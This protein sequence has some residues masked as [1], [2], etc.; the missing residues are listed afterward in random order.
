MEN[1]KLKIAMLF[2]ADDS[3]HFLEAFF[4]K[5]PDLSCT[6]ERCPLDISPEQI[7]LRHAPQMVVA[8]LV[9]LSDEEQFQLKD[10][11]KKISEVVPLVG[12]MDEKLKSRALEYVKI[13]MRDFIQVPFDEDDL[14]QVIARFRQGALPSALRKTGKA[15][16]FL[17]FK[18][19]VGNTF[20]AVNTAVTL[21]RMSQ[22]K[23]L[24]W[25]MALQS[26]D[27][28]F[29]LNCN[30]K[31][32]L[33]EIIQNLDQVDESYLKGVLP[34]TE[35][36]VSILPAPRRIEDMDQLTPQSVEKAL[37]IFLGYFDHIIIDGG[38]RLSDPLMPI[39]DGSCH[40]FLTSTLELI[41]LRGA[42]RCIG[43]LEQLRCSPEKIKVVVNRFNSKYEAISKEKAEEILKYEIAHF[44]SND[45]SGV[46][47]S[48]NLGQAVIDAA[49]G[50]PLN[51][52]FKAFVKKILNHFVEEKNSNNFFAGLNKVFKKGSSHV[53][54]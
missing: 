1:Y 12:L 19:G 8:D 10:K 13:G 36:G 18:G 14:V 24:L 7:F 30:P 20:L 23:V 21:A 28:P 17:N 44:F 34:P 47:Q 53:A 4:R 27:I 9:N 46:C 54:G 25:D 2:P 48:V 3:F 51:Q 43:L 49:P 5:H 31:F 40:V 42:S 35:H 22:K 50:S 15:Y 16:T 26:G 29:F 6:I 11:F 52:Q 39:I 38:N 32:S 45:Y 41:A 37:H 33:V